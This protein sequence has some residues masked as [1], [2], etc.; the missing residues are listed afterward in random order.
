MKRR[1]FLT[2]AAAL[3]LFASEAWAA[4]KHG[5]AKSSA[6]AGSTKA[7]HGKT[8]SAKSGHKQS[9]R[10]G[11]HF[12]A[13]PPPGPV[14]HTADDSVI[15]NPPPGTTAARLPPVRAAEPPSEWRT[16]EI[17]TTFNLKNAHGQSRLWLPLPLN[18]DTLFQRTL[19]HVWDGNQNNSTMRRLP[20]GDLEVFYCEWRDSN[21]GKLQLKTLVTTADRHFD[22]TKRTVAPEREDI[23]R[24]NLQA[25]QL[26]P[27]DGLAFQLGERIV[28]R[29]KD[30]VAQAKA[31]YDWVID[32]AIYDPSLPACGTGDV[33]RQLISGLYG[34]RSADINGLF[35]AICRAIGIPARCVYGLRVGPSRLFRSLGL[36]SDDATHSQHVRAEFYVPGYGWIPVD[37]SDVRRAIAM[38]ILSDRDSKLFSLRK[39]LF[40]VWEMNWVAFNVGTDVML[41]GKSATQPFLLLPQLETRDGYRDLPNNIASPYSITTRR[42]EI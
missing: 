42:A 9:G 39:I 33:R 4:K 15:E 2:S 35:V 16:Y 37:P 18:Q 12:V 3:S 11:R 14:V 22:I 24:R 10:H 28:G 31:V 6:K 25:S 17:T 1:D 19:G 8:G 26:I 41:P 13:P 36:T 30:P 34:G 32:N 21:D 27:N 5:S 40:G 38:E 7:G 29:I 23:L 20:D